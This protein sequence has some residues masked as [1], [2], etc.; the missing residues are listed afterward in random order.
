VAYFAA[1]LVR[2]ASGWAAA[3]ADL[4]EVDDLSGI[5]H[6]VGDAADDE[7][8]LLLLEQEDTWFAVVRVDGDED[9][10]VFVSD[11]AAASRSAYADILVSEAGLDKV[12]L[13]EGET[14]DEPA[15]EED[16]AE[17]EE[18]PTAHPSG[19][20]GDAAILGDLGV[21]GDSLRS[22]CRDGLLPAEALAEIADELGFVEELEAVR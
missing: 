3:E 16:E 18:E 9:P 8:V 13:D 1:L 5:A 15:D 20:A 4:D 21:G 19:P 2:T 10:R 6:Q 11:A 7:T 14:D 17:E 12:G 22:L